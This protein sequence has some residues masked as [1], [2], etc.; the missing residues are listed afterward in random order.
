MRKVSRQAAKNAKD[1]VL[2]PLRLG[3][4]LLAFSG[5]Q[6]SVETALVLGTLVVPAV[7]G[8]LMVGQAAWT[9]SSIVHLTRLG[10]QYAATH[11]FQ[12]ASGSNVIHYMQNHAPPMLDRQQLTKGPAEIQVQYWAQDPVNHQTVPFQCGDSCTSACVP[13]AVTVAVN[14]YQFSSLAQVLGLGPISMPPFATTVRVESAGGNPD[15]GQ[16]VP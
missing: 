13:D 3:E 2:A 5:G 11:C 15:T 4:K 10:A 16:S 7:F 6:A 8:L 12:D 1:L 14:N 9:W